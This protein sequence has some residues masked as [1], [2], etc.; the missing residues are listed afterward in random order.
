MNVMNARCRS[1]WEHLI[2]EWVHSELDR[3]ML[4]RYLLDDI[5]LEK[6]AE[7]VDISVV[8]CQK[9]VSLAK[10]QLLSHI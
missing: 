4:V 6:I 8:Q 5:T 9:R 10:K 1:E 7:E 2:N 3:R